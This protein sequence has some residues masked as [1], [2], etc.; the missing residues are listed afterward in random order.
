MRLGQDQPRGPSRTDDPY[1]GIPR[2]AAPHQDEPQL[3]AEPSADD[4]ARAEARRHP[5]LSASG[6]ISL[7]PEGSPAP[8]GSVALGPADDEGHQPPDV[9]VA[10]LDD[11]ATMRQ[12]ALDDTPELVVPEELLAQPTPEL[13]LSEPQPAVSP[14]PVFSQIA[15]MPTAIGG[16]LLL[17]HPGPWGSDPLQTPTLP[18]PVRRRLT[19]WSGRTGVP[20]V[21]CQRPEQEFSRSRQ[22][23]VSVPHNDG[24]L[25]ARNLA[26]V[27]ELV[28]LDLD[29]ALRAAVHCEVPTGWS[30]IEPLMAVTTSASTVQ[31][32]KGPAVAASLASMDPDN[33]WESSYTHP[34]ANTGP[35]VSVLV[36]PTN[37]VYGPLDPSVAPAVVDA[38]WQG[39]VLLGRFR[40][41]T[42][43]TGDQQV[44]EV[45]LRQ[46]LRAEVDNAIEPLDI[47]R[48]QITVGGGDDSGL[49]VERVVTRWRVF[50]TL[51][52]DPAL[53]RMVP[54][55][56]GQPA[57][58]WRVVVD[59]STSAAAVDEPSLSIVEVADEAD[60]QSSAHAW[61][62]R[63]Q[64]GQ[65]SE[66]PLPDPTVVSEVG[67]MTPGT[68]LDLGC[69]S[70]R[71]AIWLAEQGWRVTG[72]D[73]SRTGL[74]RLADEAGRR[75]VGVRAELADLRVWT[76]G[77]SGFDLVLVSFVHIDDVF[78]KVARW[79]A[80][81]GRIIV[82]GHSVRNAT[83]GVG[84]PNDRTL[85]HDYV[86]LA[87][88][89]TGARLRV[90]R[91]GEVERQTVDGVA[92]DSIVVATKPA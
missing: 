41:R 50:P 23:M 57:R 48:E 18:D 85:L 8:E 79:L 82:I 37:I 30:E 15:D 46:R 78:A 55:M 38:T 86:H 84:G 87:A 51:V 64:A 53:A 92:I 12:R 72:V 70:G 58:T 52:A 25:I 10:V 13:D 42:H 22:V 60:K 33:T 71:H 54:D 1:L 61:D 56:A 9:V 24:L 90:L 31:R 66:W 73:F 32:G 2:Q 47:T 26:D 34:H 59:S 27:D 75:R 35:D 14:T 40:G 67:T 28:E 49:T 45:A 44:A 63:H 6:E 3:M 39:K 4:L 21:L 11:R 7:A 65:G 83:D 16:Y 81:G 88:R 62:A 29:E 74:W 89:A 19:A 43:L 17:E 68:A 69:G 5:R 36:L 91:A 20:V 76:P 80:P 77:G